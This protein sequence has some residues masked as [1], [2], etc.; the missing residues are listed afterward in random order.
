[1]SQHLPDQC[2]I[3]MRDPH[4]RARGIAKDQKAQTRSLPAFTCAR[5][6][7]LWQ[8]FGACND[9]SCLRQ[10]ERRESEITQ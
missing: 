3:L 6:C 7:G 9:R 10:I 2:L 5:A 8:P 4:P 1:M